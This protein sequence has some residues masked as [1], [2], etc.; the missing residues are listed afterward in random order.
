MTHL[1]TK[2][3]RTE[4]LPALWPPTTAIWGGGQ[5]EQGSRQERQ[6]NEEEDQDN[7]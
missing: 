3:S 2:F 5:V 1:P 4:L 7:E 6:R